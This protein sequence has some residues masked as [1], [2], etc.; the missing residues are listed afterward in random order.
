MRNNT[1]ERIITRRLGNAKVHVYSNK[2]EAALDNFLDDVRFNSCI[3]G[4]V[5]SAILIFAGLYLYV[6]NNDSNTD[7]N[8]QQVNQSAPEF[9]D[10]AE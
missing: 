4:A 6:I 3:K 5:G 1:P 8:S 2:D 7:T 9:P 10:Y